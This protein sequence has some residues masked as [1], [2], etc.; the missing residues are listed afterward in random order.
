MVNNI[1]RL[2]EKANEAFQLGDLS[3]GLNYLA[4]ASKAGCLD[5]SFR[6]ATIYFNESDIEKGLF[7]LNLLSD[8]GVETAIVFKCFYNWLINKDTSNLISIL[9]EFESQVP[10]AALMLSFINNGSDYQFQAATKQVL[11]PEPKIVQILNAVPELLGDSLKYMLGQSLQ[12]SM[13]YNQGPELSGTNQVRDNYSINFS[14]VQP[15]IP[16]SI[17]KYFFSRFSGLSL[18][19]SEPP[20]LMRYTSGQ[21][22]KPHYDYI[23]NDILSKN[24]HEKKLGQ[25]VK[26][27]LYYINDDFT[28][29]ETYFNQLELTV[30]P[31]KNSLLIFDNVSSDGEL[32]T[33]S[34]HEGQAIHSGEKWLL[35]IWYRENPEN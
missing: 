9:T 21:K 23:S 6:L 15:F 32:L 28:A 5:S 30:K 27:L 4:K 34:Q 8:K 33:K 18:G 12:P 25:R 11:A 31:V 1:G 17:I 24:P 3:A 14:Q 7:Y 20:M 10:L 26:T 19:H 16:F 2:K 29:G 22:F 35:S 13:V